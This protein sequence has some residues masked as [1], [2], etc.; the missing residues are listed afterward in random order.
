MN[1]FFPSECNNELQ[2]YLNSNPERVEVEIRLG[3]FC[4][5]KF[6]PG[7]HEQVFNHVKTHLLDSSVSKG[8]SLEVFYSNTK[9]YFHDKFMKIIDLDDKS[10]KSFYM[11]KDKYNGIDNPEWNYRIASAQEENIGSTDVVFN[12]KFYRLK[13]RISF[14]DRDINGLLYGVRVDLTQV[15]TMNNSTSF[16]SFEI[17]IER[18]SRLSV[19]EFLNKFK[20]IYFLSQ[21]LNSVFNNNESNFDKFLNVTERN[22]VVKSY[23]HHFSNTSDQKLTMHRNEPANIKVEN[24]FSPNDYFVTSK[25]DGTRKFLYILKGHV[26]FL[27]PPYEIIRLSSTSLN[28]DKQWLIDGEFVNSHNSTPQF[29]AFDCLIANNINVEHLSFDKRIDL[30]VKFFTTITFNEIELH[31]KHFYKNS[32]FYTNINDAINNNITLEQN[33]LK[34]DGIIIQPVKQPYINSST[35]KWKPIDQLTIDFRVVQKTTDQYFLQSIGY[36]KQLTHHEQ[37]AITI[38][39]G[40]VPILPTGKF[41]ETFKGTR[42][43][44]HSGIVTIKDVLFLNEEINNRIIEFRWNGEFEPV[45]YRD[46]RPYPNRTDVAVSIWNDINSPISIHTITGNDLVVM[47][48][49]HNQVKSFLL[50]KFTKKQDVLLD[51]GSGRGGDLSKWKKLNLSSIYAIEPSKVNI[52]EFNSRQQ[53]I[54]TPNVKLINSFA[55]DLTQDQVKNVDAISA[56]FVLTHLSVSEEKMDKFIDTLDLILKPNGVFFGAVLDGDKVKKYNSQNDTFCLKKI[57]EWSSSPYNNKVNVNIIDK[58]SMVKDVDEYLFDFADFQRKLYK[59][60]FVLCDS[61]DDMFIDRGIDFL[62]KNSQMFSRMNRIFAFKKIVIEKVIPLKIG[63]YSTFNTHIANN[64]CREGSINDHSSLFH[65]FLQT[66]KTYSSLDEENKKKS[67]IKLRKKLASITFDVFQKLTTGN[68]DIYD[69][70]KTILLSKRIIDCFEIIAYMSYFMNVNI[71]L[72]DAKTRNLYLPQSYTTLDDKTKINLL[73]N[74][75]RNSILL[76]KINNVFETIC[77]IQDSHIFQAGS[78]TSI[79][80]YQLINQ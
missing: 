78:K 63:G 18:K 61:Y 72:I 4:K 8:G 28:I 13:N 50:E 6:R 30:C 56:F 19:D 24:L 1:T 42:F 60:G 29:Y 51:I 64:V 67:T 38:V 53:T 48:K 80:M 2:K 76:L 49:Y 52:K 37:E 36:R 71:Y 15:L 44:P 5:N 41:A 77:Q 22:Y 43:F 31:T 65:A 3:T 12:E 55:E 68:K 17:E 47:R 75:N 69:K 54:K 11:K 57:G 79:L 10:L 58:T 25:L 35:L 7:V 73:Y 23:N 16:V 74:Q 34:T 59:K 62:P 46:D 66:N 20:F 33:N 39:K 9:V 40:F 26:Y 32:D 21:K 14:V 27:S 70:I 45:R